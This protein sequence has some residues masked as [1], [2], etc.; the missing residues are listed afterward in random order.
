MKGKKKNNNWIYMVFIITFILSMVFGGLSN[1][2]LNNLNIEWAIILLLIM[3]SIGILFDIIGVAVATNDI[4]PFTAKASRKHKG[5]KEA[6]FLIKNTDKV[7]N[8]CNDIVG[9]ICGIISGAIGALLSIELNNILNWDIVLISLLVGS[10]I[11]SITVFGKALGKGYAIKNN[12]NIVYKVG[13]II[14][15]MFKNEK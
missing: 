11:S 6:I 2:I 7:T 12:T 14:H 3:I 10:V 9:D 8:I 4:S 15:F 1:T 5:A 13:R